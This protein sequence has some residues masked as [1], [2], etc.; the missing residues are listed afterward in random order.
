VLFTARP[1]GGIPTPGRE[2]RQVRWVP[3]EQI[4][5]LRMDRSMRMRVRHYLDA[6]PEPYLG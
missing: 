2:S 4:L 5:D 3:R 1:T 6:R